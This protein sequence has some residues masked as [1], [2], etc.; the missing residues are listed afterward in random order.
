LITNRK[1]CEF[2]KNC[3][4]V[5]FTASTDWT[6]RIDTSMFAS[7]D[8]KFIPNRENI[9]RWFAQ[10]DDPKK[11]YS[12]LH[13]VKWLFWLHLAAKSFQANGDKLNELIDLAQAQFTSP[14]NLGGTSPK[15]NTSKVLRDRGLSWEALENSIIEHFDFQGARERSL[16]NSISRPEQAEF[17]KLLLRHFGTKCAIS[18]NSVPEALE[19]AHIIPVQFGGSYDIGNGILLRRDLH[20]LFDIG[21]LKIETTEPTVW[22]YECAENYSYTNIHNLTAEHRKSLEKRKDFYCCAARFQIG[23]MPSPQPPHAPLIPSPHRQTQFCRCTG[24]ARIM[25][26]FP[27][28]NPP[29]TPH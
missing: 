27:L 15:Q 19:A 9:L 7:R 1:F 23:P 18:G 12:K 21:K 28:P 5:N 16:Q 6:H 3:D 13:E 8:K 24:G 20:A 2:I 10:R 4:T 26:A 17:R 29:K 11:T 25:H 22:F 14:D